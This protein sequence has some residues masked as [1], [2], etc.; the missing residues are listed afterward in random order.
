M[1]G[2][3]SAMTIPAYHPRVIRRSFLASALLLLACGRDPPPPRP[4]PNGNWWAKGVGLRVGPS[5]VELVRRLETERAPLVVE[6]PYGSTMERDGTFGVKM[7]V[8]TLKRELVTK[9]V[10]GEGADILEPLE[11]A[12]FDAEPITKGGTVNI[13]LKFSEK[14]RKVE[15]CFAQSK[16]C[17]LLEHD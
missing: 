1:T 9:R 11:T 7:T 10:K 8:E 12:T 17:T 13:T 16:K 3:G 14:D 15:M 2:L 6:G 5:R 4:L